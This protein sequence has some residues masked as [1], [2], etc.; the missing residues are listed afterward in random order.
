MQ[1]A[2]ELLGRKC[3]TLEAI[4][5]S[6]FRKASCRTGSS[7]CVLGLASCYSSGKGGLVW[8]EFGF[9]VWFFGC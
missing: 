8:F 1:L 2:C 3:S 9:L 7:Y 4:Q 5:N 6:T